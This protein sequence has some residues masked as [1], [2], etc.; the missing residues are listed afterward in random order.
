M[1]EVSS[2]S[3]PGRIDNAP[4]PHTR[5]L[6]PKRPRC[7][8]QRGE[9]DRQLPALPCFTGNGRG[10][11]LR[12]RRRRACLTPLHLTLC[13]SPSSTAA[14]TRVPHVGRAS[15]YRAYHITSVMPVGI[16]IMPHQ[17]R[18]WDERRRVVTKKS[19]PLRAC[20]E[21]LPDHADRGFQALH[22]SLFGLGEIGLKVLTFVHDTVPMTLCGVGRMISNIS[23]V[24][25]RALES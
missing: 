6:A 25:Y 23:R 3:G 5:V 9:S 24:A 10:S 21:D 12:A 11:A 16:E 20:L 14:D 2:A 7:A 8:L 17:G 13:A 1:L 19:H 18:F 22:E 15:G 4:H